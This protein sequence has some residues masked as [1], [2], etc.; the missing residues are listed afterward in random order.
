MATVAI[1]QLQNLFS[2]SYGAHMMPL[3]INNLGMDTYT[4]TYRYLHR[5]NF[6]KYSIES[7]SVK[8]ME[9]LNVH[10]QQKKGE[11]MMR[12]VHPGQEPSS[13]YLA[14]LLNFTQD[15]V[16]MLQRPLTDEYINAV[17]LFQQGCLQAPLLFVKYSQYSMHFL[18]VGMLILLSLGTGL[19][20]TCLDPLTNAESE[21]LAFHMFCY[22]A[23]IHE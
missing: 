16:M 14:K 7:N 9:C 22:T 20:I 3:V 18:N 8:C 10:A 4:H 1:Q 11:N 6:K 19:T 13:C 2:Q 5:N 17:R 23:W 21:C 12:Y 15:S